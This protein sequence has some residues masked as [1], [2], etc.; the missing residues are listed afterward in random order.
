M[1]KGRG[2]RGVDLM[3][4]LLIA[5]LILS[6]IGI[7]LHL[8][9]ATHPPEM[10]SDKKANIKRQIQ[11]TI[12]TCLIMTP[13]VVIGTLYANSIEASWLVRFLL[14][15]MSFIV[16]LTL[17]LVVFY[18]QARLYYEESYEELEKQ[19]HNVER[20]T[21]TRVVDDVEEIYPFAV[22]D[23]VIVAVPDNEENV[24][25]KRRYNLIT[26]ERKVDKIYYFDDPIDSE[27]RHAYVSADGI[28][29][30]LDKCVGTLLFYEQKA[31]EEWCAIFNAHW[32]EEN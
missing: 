5:C 10:G 23:T 3:N 17:C 9:P 13:L 15:L 26:K 14:R 24:K 32:D 29:Y 16:P 19:I 30:E 8:L 22:G 11:S 7:S 31:A 12:Y 2:I 28:L 27:K 1:P 18:I 25:Q 21:Y 20:Y 4:N 6:V